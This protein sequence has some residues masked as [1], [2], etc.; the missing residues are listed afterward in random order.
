MGDTLTFRG[1]FRHSHP[2]GDT[3]RYLDLTENISIES[4]IVQ[5]IYIFY[6][7]KLLRKMSVATEMVEEVQAK[8]VC[9][10][11]NAIAD[12]EA[13]EHT[14]RAYAEHNREPIFRHLSS[15]SQFVLD[16]AIDPTNY[17]P[18]F[19]EALELFQCDGIG[20]A[21]DLL[22]VAISI[23]YYPLAAN[24]FA[25]PIN[26]V[27]D[28]IGVSREKLRWLL[29]EYSTS[30]ERDYRRDLLTDAVL[31]NSEFAKAEIN[32]STPGD[33]G[34]GEPALKQQRSSVVASTLPQRLNEKST[35]MGVR[36][37]IPVHEDLEL[38]N[39]DNEE[40]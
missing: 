3:F 40:L 30:D 7:P 17:D 18:V 37:R 36:E 14:L 31:A 23:I 32:N 1:Y 20:K 10:C 38:L 24:A 22:G 33:R 26:Q 28:G 29:L 13:I 35:L 25:L 16:Q 5:S 27:V 39:L 4:A 11:H 9:Y 8:C 12:L 19:A 6:Y 21:R 15:K 2:F 34:S